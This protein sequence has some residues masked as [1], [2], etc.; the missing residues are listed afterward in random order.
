MDFR[1]V[2]SE[3]SSEYTLTKDEGGQINDGKYIKGTPHDYKIDLAIF[4]LEAEEAQ[5][6][7]GDKYTTEDI[8]VYTHS[9]P[10][11]YDVDN[12]INTTI[13][14]EKDDIIS[15]DNSDYKIDKIKSYDIHGKF[16]RCVAK[17]VVV[18]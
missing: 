9:N 18:E 6:Y 4:P 12:D 10:E 3:Y 17:K 5:M 11:A 8:V 2:I 14:I 13:N 1:Q 7:E 16:L 15:L